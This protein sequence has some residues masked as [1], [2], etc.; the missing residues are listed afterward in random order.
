MGKAYKL[1]KYVP[2]FVYIVAVFAVLMNFFYTK[3]LVI[4]NCPNVGE[5]FPVAVLRTAFIL[6]LCLGPVDTIHPNTS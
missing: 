3:I 6:L 4:I 2:K 5:L 1:L